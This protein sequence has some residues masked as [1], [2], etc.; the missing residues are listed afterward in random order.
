MSPI[1]K[2]E[3]KKLSSETKLLLQPDIHS[4]IFFYPGRNT[5][6]FSIFYLT[7][8]ISVNTT[9]NAT[10]QHVPQSPYKPR[11]QRPSL[12]LWVLFCFV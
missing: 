7:D 11:E 3:G 4:G 5:E 1:G 10:L 9:L 8:L 6:M 2:Q 12:L